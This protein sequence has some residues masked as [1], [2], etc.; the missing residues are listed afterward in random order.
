MPIGDLLQ[1]SGA[2][3]E[4]LADGLGCQRAGGFGAQPGGLGGQ[5]GDV[6]VSAG[7]VRACRVAPVQVR[8]TGVLPGWPAGV[9]QRLGRIVAAGQERPRAVVDLQGRIGEQGAGLAG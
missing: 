5:G 1:P 6:L 8:V 4:P 7:D 9:A 3:G 2:L